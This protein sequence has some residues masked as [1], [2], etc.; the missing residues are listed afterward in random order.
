MLMSKHLMKASTYEREDVA[1][2]FLGLSYLIYYN[3]FPL[4]C[5]FHDFIDL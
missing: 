2:E 3:F 4:T 5:K 1:F